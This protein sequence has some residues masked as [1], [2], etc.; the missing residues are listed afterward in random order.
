MYVETHMENDRDSITDNVQPM[1]IYFRWI[2]DKWETT[3]EENTGRYLYDSRKGTNSEI[4]SVK[5][6]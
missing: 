4:N 1:Q 3:V 5:S 2:N 6:E